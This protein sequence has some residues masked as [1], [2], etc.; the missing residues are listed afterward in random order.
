M[1]DFEKIF[2]QKY[3]LTEKNQA[4]R[5]AIDQI[6]GPVLVIAGPGI[7]TQAFRFN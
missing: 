3:A 6:F 2:Q 5:E 4:Q 1:T 7:L